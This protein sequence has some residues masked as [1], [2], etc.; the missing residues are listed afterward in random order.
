MKNI[1][2]YITAP[3][4]FVM[5]CLG[6]ESTAHTFGVGIVDE[7]G[8]ILA[9]EK[10]VY[11]TEK[12]GMIPR[13]VAEH[14]EKAKERVL[15]NALEK[16][17][18]NNEEIDLI[19]FS[20]GPGLAPCL[21]VGRDF[22]VGLARGLGKPLVGV[23][24]ICA[25]LE[26]GKLLT[27]AK[28]PIFVFTS[29]ANTQIIAHE[30]RRYRVF[31]E[32]LSIAIGNALDKFGRA[33]GLG[34][35]AGAKIEEIAKKGR[36]VELPYKVKG[37]DVDF[38]GIVTKALNLYKKGEEKIEDLCFSL[39]E[40]CFAMLTEV[41]ERAVAHCDKKEV[42]L[43]GGVAANK[44]LCEMLGA[45]CK[46]RLAK[47]YAVPLEYAGDQGAMTAWQGLLQFKAGR[48][49]SCPPEKADIKPRW[50]VDDVETFW[51]K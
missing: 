11:T 21:L 48:D 1:K 18:I 12:G 40:T 30:G 23:N 4:I 39:Q 34:F 31:G 16:C 49:C 33:V 13:E 27:R 51:I 46:A 3:F 15:E 41:A 22:A 6:I 28:D 8:G 45:M 19:S 36:Y 20:Q 7:T 14:H 37:M 35:P 9:N 38:S 10:K 26:I 24:H 47:F 5:I 2:I 32:C 25:H 50:R 42:L 29:G 44:R 17:G 43:I